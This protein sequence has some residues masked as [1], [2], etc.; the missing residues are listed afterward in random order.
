MTKR[1]RIAKQLREWADYL[2][3]F[4]QNEPVINIHIDNMIKELKKLKK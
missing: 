2:E 3:K 1:F 4:E